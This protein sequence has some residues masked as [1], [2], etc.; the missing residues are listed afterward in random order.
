MPDNIISK[1]KLAPPLYTR[2]LITLGTYRSRLETIQEI[3]QIF[4]R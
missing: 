2:T 1:T 3:Q 4:R